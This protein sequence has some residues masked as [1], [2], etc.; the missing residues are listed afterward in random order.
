[1]GKKKN[2]KKRTG[3]M[4][5]L[6]VLCL[7]LAVELCIFVI[8][9][10]LYG[11]AGDMAFPDSEVT[12]SPDLIPEATVWVPTDAET[13]E[14]AAQ[15][16]QPVNMGSVLDFPVLL[17]DGKLE[18]ESLFRFDGINPDCSNAEQDDIV[19]VMIRNVS[20]IFLTEAEITLEMADGK[21]VKFAVTN[22]PAGKTAMVFSA[23]NVS[24]K[25]DVGCVDVTC[26]AL[27]AETVVALPE[28]VAV[29]V[30]GVTVTLENQ[31]KNDIP[32]LILYCH[33]LLDEDYFGGI[34]YVYKV[35]NLPAGETVT[36]EAP[37]C[38]MGLAE[39]AR[40]TIN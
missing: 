28:E 40:I 14:T 15:E 3:K 22:L 39:V 34:S 8:P 30:D 32:E 31:T 21:T 25:E 26:E 36:V 19:T 2:T 23:D 9:Q 20:E 38:I 1:M 7:I 24:A 33:S 5:A 37:E 11:Q 17:E 27:W 18:I 29:S 12:E 35:E 4:I 10:A 6:V 16:T 13:E